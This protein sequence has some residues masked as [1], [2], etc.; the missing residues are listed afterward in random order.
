MPTKSELKYHIVWCTK[1]RRKVLNESSGK[2]Y[3]SINECILDLNIS[4][5]CFYR[6]IK[7]PEKKLKLI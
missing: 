2:I 5:D 6:W 3:N 7:N 1:Y 4:R